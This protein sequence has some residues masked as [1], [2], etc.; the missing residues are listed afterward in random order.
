MSCRLILLV[1][2]L[3][4]TFALSS[5]TVDCEV[6]GEESGVTFCATAEE[7]KRSECSD[8]SDEVI[9][10]AASKLDYDAADIMEAKQIG[11]T[12]TCEKK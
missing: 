10:E 3:A 4:A 12:F 6:C 11:V 8:C 1:T 5:C 9:H 2:G 7:V